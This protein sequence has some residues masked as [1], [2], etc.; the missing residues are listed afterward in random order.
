MKSSIGS[1]DTLISGTK[2]L[3]M[4]KRKPWKKRTARLI[5]FLIAVAALILWFVPWQ[6]TII[7]SGEVIVFDAMQRPQTVEAQI[8]GRITKWLVNEGQTV[9]E[10]DQI[11]EIEDIESRFLAP[12]QVARFTRQVE[13]LKNARDSEIQ[14]ITEIRNQIS[15]AMISQTQRQKNASET[16]AQS[17]ERRKI[18]LQILRASQ[19]NLKI[20]QRVAKLSANE[21]LAQANDAVKQA[22]QSVTAAKQK[23]AL[24]KLQRARVR[25]LFEKG[26]ES[27]RADEVSETD[28]VTS[29]TNVERAQLALEIAKRTA[30]IGTLTVD[31]ANLEIERAKAAVD[32]ASA[33]VAVADRDV[34]TAENN[35][36][37]IRANT[38]ERVASLQAS[39]R[40][41][42]A[43]ISR[44][45]S[46]LE[47]RG[48]DMSQLEQRRD[49]KS[50]V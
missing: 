41:G 15:Q 3:E 37:D 39:L 23:L 4:V 34:E 16:F 21:R 7:G 28:L 8:P 9:H 12:D 45:E 32:Q 24:D 50:V 25:E 43:T 5:L 26:L 2:S 48:I 14:R 27:K 42:E 31:Q 18:S 40:A 10:G 1:T 46:D 33:S 30:S 17:L 38:E 22:E 6:Q 19:Q 47:A 49:R 35:I 36:D 44:L 29:Q 20:A 11:A 13:G